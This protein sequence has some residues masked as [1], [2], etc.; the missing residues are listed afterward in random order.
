MI[1][2]INIKD[3]AP[4]PE[5]VVQFTS[6]SGEI[7]MPELPDTIEPEPEQAAIGDDSEITG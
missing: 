7:V 4:P 3:L 1:F 2:S 6:K 5:V